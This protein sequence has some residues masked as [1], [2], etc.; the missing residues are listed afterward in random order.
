MSE[1]MQKVI[2][3]RCSF[4]NGH[5]TYSHS[6]FVPGWLVLSLQ[7]KSRHSQN[8]LHGTL[9]LQKPVESSNVG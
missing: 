3:Y 9:F 7:L 2:V 5:Q 4:S 6:S 1:K 8:S